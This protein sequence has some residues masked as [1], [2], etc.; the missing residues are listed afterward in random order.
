MSNSA[1]LVPA[2]PL[3]TPSSSSDYKSVVA[4]AV[5]VQRKGPKP[6][7]RKVTA[8][9][10]IPGGD[11]DASGKRTK[12]VASRTDEPKPKELTEEE[13]ESVKRK[14]LELNRIAASKSRKKK[15]AYV[16]NLNYAVEA[17]RKENRTFWEENN[18]L[19]RAYCQLRDA[20]ANIFEENTVLR[21]NIDILYKA[22]ARALKATKDSSLKSSAEVKAAVPIVEFVKK[23]A[24]QSAPQP[25]KHIPVTHDE[26]ASSVDN[27]AYRFP[28]TYA[29]NYPTHEPPEI[30]RNASA[31][32]GD[33]LSPLQIVKAVVATTTEAPKP[34]NPRVP[35]ATSGDD[36]AARPAQPKQP[37][38]ANEAAATLAG[39]SSN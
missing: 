17:L 12:S 31:A 14:R 10:T 5:V 30:L 2:K 9:A 27:L 7:A 26:N 39:L 35:K 25:F 3:A 21:R 33:G 11:G 8:T 13:K 38:N 24:A 28:A 29:A 36:S 1:P 23:L 37:G 4:S 22:Y 20:H 18:R 6:R 32:S 16:A 15:K 34:R 19:T